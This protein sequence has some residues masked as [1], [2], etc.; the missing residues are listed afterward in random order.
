[1]T[2]V[3]LLDN[4]VKTKDHLLVQ[5]IITVLVKYRHKMEATLVEMRKLLPRSSVPRTSQPSTQAA[6][7]PS[8]KGKAQQML[9]DL[10]GCLQ[11]CKVQEAVAAATKI[12]VPTLEVSPVAVL[13]I[14][15]KGKSKESESRAASS[16]PASQK[17][18]K[19]KAKVPTS[20]VRD[21]EEEEESTT[22]DSNES[23]EEELPSTPPPD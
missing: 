7:P 18:G 16:E 4:E 10:K 12:V 22:E 19:K 8:P 1:M 5:K 2:K 11:E 13:G 3:H 17:S 15:P 14:T 9:D 21:L 6:V 20:E 23:D